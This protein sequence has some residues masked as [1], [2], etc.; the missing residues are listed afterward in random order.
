MTFHSNHRLHVH[1]D[2]QD[3]FKLWIKDK[4]CKVEAL[5][6][7]SEGY[8]ISEIRKI[9]TTVNVECASR[10][11]SRVNE[12]DIRNAMETFT[13]GK[14]E[15][16]T[17]EQILPNLNDVGGMR[18]QIKLLE[19]VIVWPKKYPKL[20]ESVGVPVSK[21][22]LLYGPSGCG[23]TLLANAMI[24]FSK[25]NLISVKGPELLS[26]YIGSSE[27]NVRNV[28]TKARSCAPCILFFDE[29]DSLAPK[30]GSDSTGVTDRVVNQLLT[31]ID[32][33]EDIYSGVIVI[34]CTSRID[35]IDEALL[36][37]GRF[38]HHVRCTYPSKD[39][40]RDIIRVVTRE[41]N[42]D[43]S[44][45]MEK[46]VESTVGWSG[47]DLK[48][49]FTN[50][51]F[52]AN[53]KLSNGKNGYQDNRALIDMKCLS[54]VFE[55]SMP[56]PKLSQVDHTYFNPTECEICAIVASEWEEAGARIFRK[57]YA[58]FADISDD[59]CKR[60]NAF[61]IHKEKTG[62]ERFSKAP[63]KTIESL[64][65]LRN[66]GVE[67]EIGLPYE[68]WDQPS[69]EI[70]LLRYGCEKIMENYEDIIEIWFFAKDDSR[71]LTVVFEL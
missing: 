51:L 48:A 65:Y 22:I 68:L 43:K 38:D 14:M 1:K 44:V 23:K 21:G 63:S 70:T 62:I 29:L 5:V 50:A 3:L 49:L 57:T 52:N 10:G 31:E 41:L 34:G 39:E 71:N 12:L 15:K 47:A 60:M 13:A 20:F 26:K 32:G 25:F 46:V 66:R 54:E 19:Q 59:F 30:R 6:E 28:F 45:D 4:Y 35:L 2:R 64:K 69:Q 37:P 24:E 53:R 18:E 33:A 16:E 27:E 7:K 11:S 61:K 55:D 42:V 36:R 17:F 9:A 58:D 40:R 56:K 67:V 8:S